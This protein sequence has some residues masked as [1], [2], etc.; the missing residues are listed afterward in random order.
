MEMLEAGEDGG[1]LNA[2]E[3]LVFNANA[4]EGGGDDDSVT[5]FIA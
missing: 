2:V 4:K 3:N 5:V 1:L